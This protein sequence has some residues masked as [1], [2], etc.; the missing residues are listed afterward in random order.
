M[1]RMRGYRST[2]TISELASKSAEIARL[3]PDHV[4]RPPTPAAPF[5]PMTLHTMQKI[6]LLWMHESPVRRH[7][8]ARL[9]EDTQDK[10]SMTDF[11]A[12]RL[13]GLCEYKRGKRQHE[14]TPQGLVAAATLEKRLCQTLGIHVKLGGDDNMQGSTRFYCSCGQ[15]SITRPRNIYASQ[16]S[17]WAFLAHC[18]AARIAN[19][20]LQRMPKEES[21]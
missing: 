8:V 12:L 4:W 16:N 7:V 10:P 18:E 19:E 21:A 2:V 14:L 20:T 5:D 15:W 13:L 3:Y 9:S 6:A 17:V 1:S 11:T